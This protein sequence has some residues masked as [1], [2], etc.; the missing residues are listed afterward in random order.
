VKTLGIAVDK[1]EKVIRTLTDAWKHGVVNNAEVE[2]AISK[3]FWGENV[4]FG[5]PAQA[6]YDLLTVD[7]EY[8]TFAT[9]GTV[10]SDKEKEDKEVT[11]NL[12]IEYIHN[13][14]HGWVGGELGGHMSQ[15]PV[16]SFDPLFWL[17]HW[18]VFLFVKIVRA[19][20]MKVADATR[21]LAT[22]TASL[23]CGRG[24]TLTSGSPR[25]R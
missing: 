20:P 16:A 1:T 10:A 2:R 12:N 8:S 21:T 11:D 18:Y 14:V 17:H 4:D 23:L 13:M 24:S 9:T 7:I 3:P 22:L 5:K 25:V 19:M 6:V 15:I